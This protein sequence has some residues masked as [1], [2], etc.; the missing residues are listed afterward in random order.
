[1]G[2]STSERS[3]GGSKDITEVQPKVFGQ[4]SKDV[5]QSTSRESRQQK[6]GNRWQGISGGSEETC[7]PARPGEEQYEWE[8]PRTVV[9]RLGGKPYGSSYRN[10][11]L[12]LLGN[13]VVP[14]TAELAWRTLWKEMDNGN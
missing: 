14:Q 13:G 1:L 11:R 6:A 9:T 5:A 2:N 3:C 10:K 7:W 12:A 8:S 4:G